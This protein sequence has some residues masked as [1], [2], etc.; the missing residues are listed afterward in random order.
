MD[1]YKDQSRSFEERATDL[2]SKMTLEEKITHV[3]VYSA[4][5]PRLGVSAYHY[6]NEASHGVFLLNYV[7]VNKYDVTS[8]PVCLAMSQSWDCDKMKKVT[9]A[10]SDE[11]RAYSNEKGETLNFFCPTINLARDPRNGRSDENFG[12]DPYL[13][14]KMAASYIRGLQG[15]DKKYLKA[16]ATPKHYML[17]SSENNRN[18]GS[19]NA[20]EATIREYYG[21]VF[22][23]AIKE[24]K[25]ESIMTSYNRI[26]GV[27]ASTNDFMLTTLLREEWGFDG[28]VVSDCGAVTNV[29]A[30]RAARV[31]PTQPAHYYCK[32]DL[33]ASA[34]TLIAGTDNSCGSEHRKYLL[35]AIQK[36]LINEDIVDR[37]VIRNLL[38]RFRLGEFDDPASVPYSCI[39]ID[40]AS[41]EYAH[42]MSVDMANDTIVLLKNEKDLLPLKTDKI[43]KILVVGPNAKFR[44]LGGY[45]AGR[46]IDTPVN[47]MTLD[48]VK[49]AVAGSGI[50]VAYEKGWCV[51][52]EFG[53][54]GGAMRALPGVDIGEIYADMFG[55]DSPGK[56]L[57]KMFGAPPRHQIDDPD[58]QADGDQLFARALNAAKESDVVIMVVGTDEVTASE[59]HDRETLEPPYGQNEKIKK[60]LDTNP[61]TVVVL[62]TLGTMTGDALDV[63]HTLV[64]AHFAGEAQGTAIANVLFGKVNPN[65]KLTATWYKNMEDLPHINEYGIKKQDTQQKKARTYMYFDGEVRFPF[66]Y[67]LSYTKYDYSSIKVKKSKLDANDTLEVSVDV[68]NAG[69]MAGKEIV[70]LYISKVAEQRSNKPSRQLK[71]FA[72]VAL[73]AGETKTVTISVPLSEVTFWS[74]FYHKM[75]VEEGKYVVEVGRSSADL[76]CKAEITVSG[77]WKPELFNVYAVA[78]KYCM[79]VGDESKLKVS[80]TLEDAT[81]LCMCEYRPVFTSSDEAVAA[82]DEHGT[83]TAKAPGVATITAAVTYAGKTLFAKVPLA[84]S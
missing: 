48:G 78:S 11:A 2:V 13:A 19:S 41:S 14:G 57:A 29:Y 52:K 39:G 43:K 18:T 68:T 53:V 80:A 32:D 65:A 46:L 22:E 6:T 1:I 40:K 30:T 83:V 49:N 38:S 61:N 84:V 64:N 66:G 35:K 76:P 25:A 74:N 44:Q 23:R 10:I 69:S 82:V 67:G 51:A 50:E 33:E 75:M 71:G 5:I 54:A 26:N 9:S 7:N 47:V 79:N 21:K 63:A 3:G 12:E 62:V 8:Y 81:H 15:D 20:D 45:S 31:D 58:Y 77:E 70:E 56:D 34:L 42:G 72:K 28:F 37:A 60:M 55:I 73:E 16:V 36:E 17:N 24:G 27:P 59:E 4:A